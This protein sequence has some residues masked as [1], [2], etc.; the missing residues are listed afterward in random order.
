MKKHDNVLN[1]TLS[2]PKQIH[3][4]QPV[5]YASAKLWTFISTGHH[6]KRV[7]LIVSVLTD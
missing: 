2:G 7:D 5:Y 1:G 3:S 6:G 4:N